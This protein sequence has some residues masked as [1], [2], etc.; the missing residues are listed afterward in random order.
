MLTSSSGDIMGD[1]VGNSG[2][3][4]VVFFNNDVAVSLFSIVVAVSVVNGFHTD[5]DDDDDNDNINDVDANDNDGGDEDCFKGKD[6]VATDVTAAEENRAD[7][8]GDDATG[9]DNDVDAAATDIV[10]NDK[11]GNDA[12]VAVSV[13]ECKIPLPK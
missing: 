2:N 1:V 11:Q 6:A 12:A 4:D 13:R 9:G 7:A 10:S 5:S 3:G 8:N